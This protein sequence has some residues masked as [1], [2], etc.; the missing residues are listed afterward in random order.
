MTLIKVFVFNAFQ[1]NTYVLYDS[2]GQCVIVDPG[3]SQQSEQQ[4]L[5]DF[6]GKNHLTPFAC[7]NTHT[8]IDH[9]LGDAF[10][11]K[12]YNIELL[13]HQAGLPFLEQAPVYADMFGLKLSGQIVPRSNIGEQVAFGDSILDVLY[14]PGHVDGSICL[15]NHAARFVLTGDVLFNG[16]VGRTDLQT[17]NFEILRQSISSKLY[18]LPDDYVVYPGHGASTTIGHEKSNNPFIRA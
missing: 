7:I 2:T 15:V 13:I 17:G 11:C 12:M 14:T 3:C 10:V 16:S 9:V 6:I 4:L 1:V 8:H 5:D 18:T